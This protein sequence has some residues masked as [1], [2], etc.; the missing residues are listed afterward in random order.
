MN[1]VE[2]MECMKKGGKA[3]RKDSKN[4]HYMEDNVLYTYLKDKKKTV[5][6]SL[7]VSN[8]NDF[9]GDNWEKYEPVL[10]DTEKKYIESIIAPFKDKVLYIAKRYAGE[11]KDLVNIVIRVE[12]DYAA[13]AFEEIEL[14]V[15]ELSKYGMYKNMKIG[16][17]YRLKELDL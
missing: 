11:C 17:T 5:E 4:I 16:K 12:S 9:Y 8:A 10:D 3:K 15:F 2:A 14:P 13:P 7:L 6:A 1:L